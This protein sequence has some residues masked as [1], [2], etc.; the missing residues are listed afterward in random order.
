MWT[1]IAFAL[2]MTLG[3]ASAAAAA[4]KYPI[5]HHRGAAL[6]QRIPA[7]AYRSF[8]RVNGTEGSGTYDSHGQVTCGSDACD[9][10]NHQ[11]VKCIGG[12]CDPE[13]GIR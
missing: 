10:Y 1:K 12:A 3:A 8:G 5:H 7:A 6:E 11:Q 2:A 4:T 13:W 9:P